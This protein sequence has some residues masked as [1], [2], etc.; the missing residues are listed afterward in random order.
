MKWGIRESFPEPWTHYVGGFFGCIALYAAVIFGGM[1]LQWIVRSCSN[2]AWPEIRE[3][4]KRRM[5]EGGSDPY[6]PASNEPPDHIE[7]LPITR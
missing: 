1:G 7:D 4:Q 6:D 3:E 2:A 5:L